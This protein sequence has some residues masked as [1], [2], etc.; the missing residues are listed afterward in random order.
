VTALTRG[1]KVCAFVERYCIVPEGDLIGQPVKLAGFQKRF[2]LAVYDNPAGTRRGYLS[3]AR[4][5]AKTATIAC[6]LLAHIAGP[7]AIL[8]S[9]ILSGG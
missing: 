5:N 2:I 4:K 7:E 3:I 8:N 1:Q 9:S 6:I